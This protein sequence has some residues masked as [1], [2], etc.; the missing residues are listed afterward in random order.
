[1]DNS[2]NMVAAFEINKNRA[3]E[4]MTSVDFSSHSFDKM[5]GIIKYNKEGRE[6]WRNYIYADNSHNLVQLNNTLILTMKTIFLYRQLLIA[7][8]KTINN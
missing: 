3:S 4:F 5:I 6:L 2:E 7:I 1:M 8:V